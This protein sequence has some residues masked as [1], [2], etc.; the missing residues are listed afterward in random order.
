MKGAELRQKD[1][2][3]MIRL[4]MFLSFLNPSPGSTAMVMASANNNIEQYLA[5]EMIEAP[6]CLIKLQRFTT[7]GYDTAVAVARTLN[8]NGIA[9]D[10]ALAKALENQS[11]NG[12]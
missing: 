6:T 11:I 10:E 7:A 2:S 8:N 5:I 12:A 4:A 9:I 1:R 3:W